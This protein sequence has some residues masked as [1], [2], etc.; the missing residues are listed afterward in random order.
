MEI[1]ADSLKINILLNIQQKKISIIG[2]FIRLNRINL[3]SFSN[4][5]KL[6]RSNLKKNYLLRITSN[7]IEID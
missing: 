5:S 2:A 3:I 4:K 1:Q 6:S 7:S